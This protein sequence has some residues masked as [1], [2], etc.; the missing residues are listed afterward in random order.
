MS[1]TPLFCTVLIC[2]A[3]VLLLAKAPE[4]IP[5]VSSAWWQIAD[6]DYDAG[7]WNHKPEPG[8]QTLRYHQQV[9]DFTIYQSSDGMWQLVSAVR[10]TSFPGTAHFLFRWESPSLS[11]P[12]WE[13]KGVLWTTADSSPE[14]GYTEGVLFAPHVVRDDDGTFYMFHNSADT[15]QFLVSEDG[16]EWEQGKDYQGNYV[17][18]ETGEAGRDLMVLDNRAVDGNWIVY[19][20]TIDRDRKALGPRQFTDVVARTAQSLKGPWSEPHIV[21]MGTPDRPRDIVHSRVDFVNAESPFVVFHEGWYFKFEQ[22]QVAASRDPLRFEGAPLVA[23]LFP[24][25]DYPEDWWPCLAP[26]VIQDGEDTYIAFF[27]NHH[28]HPLQSLKQGGVFLAKLS[29]RSAQKSSN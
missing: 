26:E 14:A 28:R 4:M 19:Y 18:F 11:Q 1:N 17:L 3:H 16:I 21:G 8:E 2:M 5:V 22:T 23:N 13:E 6:E 24:F 25:F 15:A 12:L 20:T 9:S 7:P 10:H 27:M 29:W